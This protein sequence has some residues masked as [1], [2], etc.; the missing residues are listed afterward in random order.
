MKL[1]EM[2]KDMKIKHSVFFL[3]KALNRGKNF[4]GQIHGGCFTWGLMIKS[5]H[6]H[7]GRESFTDAFSRILNTKS[8]NF[9]WSWWETHLK[10]NLNQSLELWKEF[11]L[12]L[13]VKR[14]QR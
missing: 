10:I 12:R 11:S 1:L 3:K 9:P 14:F 2:G 8:E 5:Y 13:M 4:L 7:G 6:G